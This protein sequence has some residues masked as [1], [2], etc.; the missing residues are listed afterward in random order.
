MQQAT[1]RTW[2]NQ[3]AQTKPN[4]GYRLIPISD[5]C[6]AWVAYFERRVPLAALN[7]WFAC[8]ELRKRREFIEA[9]R[10][11]KY[12]IGELVRLTGGTEARARKSLR[13]LKRAGLIT[14]SSTELE[15]HT[16]AELHNEVGEMLELLELGRRGR[17]VPFPREVLKLLAGGATKART[18][19]ILG[20]ALRVLH[21]GGRRQ[22][23]CTGLVKASAIAEAFGVSLRAVKADRR[24][25]V[26]LGLLKSVETPQW[27]LNRYGLRLTWDLS[28]S[29][30]VDNSSVGEGT[31]PEKGASS[32][33]P[34][35]QNG[36]SSAP[37][38]ETGISS[39][40][41]TTQTTHAGGDGSS[42]KKRETG[43]PKHLTLA[44][45]RDNARLQQLFEREVA[46]G[47]LVDEQAAMVELFAA[48][49]HAVATG[50]SNPCGLFV[51]T[52]KSFRIR[53]DPPPDL[54]RKK[55]YWLFITQ[56]DEE[57]ARARVNQLNGCS[58]AESS[59]GGAQPEQLGN[60]PGGP[61][62]GSAGLSRDALIVGQLRRRFRDSSDE[63]VLR[64][65]Q[66]ERPEW[67][68]QRW[69][70]ARVELATQ[71]VVRQR[72]AEPLSS[73]APLKAILGGLTRQALNH[74]EAS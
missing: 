71:H 72:D 5:L 60:N 2:W 57:A 11:P 67:T 74:R 37:P 38:I 55:R 16:P 66:R 41:S 59:G 29:R 12:R 3:D 54:P 14:S 26:D 32:A 4:G 70:D 23:R 6:A 13:D 7:T 20:H 47:N 19:T 53:R 73:R 64:R 1:A 31:R 39:T 61:A 9:G 34:Q 17:L 45:L 58:Q 43:T 25:L 46:A 15:F 27:M 40:R 68:A 52:L 51:A 42:T 8:Q 69:H 21:G 50:V 24:A 65:L 30:A 49:E 62:A 44:D 36:A 35:V 22:V 10:T 28:W 18:A 56:R 48:A 63:E 33:P